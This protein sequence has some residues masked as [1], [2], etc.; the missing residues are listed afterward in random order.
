[1]TQE[2]TV[3]RAL[4]TSKI[5]S[6]KI[7]KA[8]SRLKLYAT[9]EGQGSMKRILGYREGVTDEQVTEA[10]QADYKSVTDMI[11]QR[12]ALKAAVIASNATTKVTIANKEMTVAEA[13]EFKNSIA[14]KTQLLLQLRK[15]FVN[16]NAEVQRQQ[17]AFESK[18]QTAEAN[19][20]GREKK[21]TEEER[22]V[23][24]QPIYMRSEPSSI[25]P[26]NL[27]AEI[28][29]LE[30]EIEDFKA[31]VDFVLSESNAKTTVTV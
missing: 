28:K 29:K 16:M 1:M 22:K 23:I 11:A 5:L 12:S 17:E 14:L 20:Q 2:I 9:A 18:L 13:I 24:T 25:D 6:E 26:I 15:Q 4:A 10:M 30:A 3:T 19:A 7:E 27:E 21:I 8:V 31:E